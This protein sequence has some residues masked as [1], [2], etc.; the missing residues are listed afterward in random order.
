MLVTIQPVTSM[1]YTVYQGGRNV[2]EVVSWVSNVFQS[3]EWLEP[4]LP[5]DIA[6]EVLVQVELAD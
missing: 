5:L 4:L 3:D 2:T 6:Y 1:L